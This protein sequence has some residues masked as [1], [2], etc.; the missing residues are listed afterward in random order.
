MLPK[1]PDRLIDDVRAVF[2]G[3][4][5]SLQ[6]VDDSRQWHYE[7]DAYGIWWPRLDTDMGRMYLPYVEPLYQHW[8][9]STI[10]E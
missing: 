10:T 1:Q 9:A 4:F 7:R 2:H 5:C 8:L 3:R 6:F